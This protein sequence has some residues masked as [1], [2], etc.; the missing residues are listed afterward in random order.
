MASVKPLRRSST[1]SDVAG[2]TT[3]LTQR[4]WNVV[5]WNDPVTPMKVVVVIFKKVFGY[6]NNKCTQLMLSVHNDG[7]AVVWSGP[8][9][10]AE[11]YCVKL[12]VSGLQSTVEQDA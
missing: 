2:E 3:V 10:R 1:E 4:P 7:R 5:V 9:E 8:R 11:S 12:Q 6:S